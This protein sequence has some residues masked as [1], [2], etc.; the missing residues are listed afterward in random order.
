M[1]AVISGCAK[2]EIHSFVDPDFREHSYRKLVVRVDVDQ[3]DQRDAAETVF[4][5]ILAKQGVQCLRT[6]D[7][8]PPTRESSDEQFKQAVAQSAADGVLTVRVTE[9]YEDEVYVP[10]SST[11]YTTGTAWGNTYYR[12]G[13]GPAYGTFDSTTYT[14]TSGGYTTT[15]PRVR[16]KVQLWDVQTGKVAW[17]GGAFT[18][19]DSRC[20]YEQLMTS[21][22]KKVAETLKSEGLVKQPADG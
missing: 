16:H 9:Q 18:E 20:G 14:T 5:K 2:T 19:G 8:L 7:L 10:P 1:A 6:L 21:L 15:Q 3:L 12:R 11:T 13:R 17:I 22:A 4:A